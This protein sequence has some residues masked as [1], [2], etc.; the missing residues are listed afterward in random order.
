VSSAFVEPASRQRFRSLLEQPEEAIDLA[1]AALL[2]A[3]EEY[4]DLDVAAYRARFVEL[5]AEA[6]ARVDPQAGARELVRGLS[7]FLFDELR[8]KGNTDAYYDP[9]NSFLNEVL[10]R[11]LGIPISLSALYIAVGRQAGLQV[12]GVGLPGHFVVRVTGPDGATLADPFHGGMLLSVQDCQRRLDRIFDGKLKLEPAMLQP[13]G[14]RQILTRMLYNLKGIYAQAE[15]HARALAIVELLLLLAPESLEE[16]RDRGLLYA[17]L[18]CYGL[19]IRDLGFYLDRAGR[20]PD[21]A[22][23]SA[24]LETLRAKRARVN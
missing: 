17:A 8:F 18:D 10:N 24:T 14:T 16:L 11:R 4:P 21:A 9:R 12:E 22:D 2:I 19:A 13:C 5:G 1:E 23:L 15:D 20:A 7:G 6:R 3:C